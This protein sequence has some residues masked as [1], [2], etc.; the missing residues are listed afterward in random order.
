MV[1]ARSKREYLPEVMKNR[2]KIDY[3]LKSYGKRDRGGERLQGNGPAI[4]H[5]PFP[6]SAD[7]QRRQPI[8]ISV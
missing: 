8:T 6:A 4:W 2:G 3:T 5:S 7:I 1:F